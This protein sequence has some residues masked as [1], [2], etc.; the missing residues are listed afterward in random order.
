[1][2]SLGRVMNGQTSEDT[3]R[4]KS[5][6]VAFL[7]AFAC[8]V[9]RYVFLYS[10]FCLLLIHYAIVLCHIPNC[11][12]IHRAAG[13]H[14]Y[15]VLVNLTC[16]LFRIIPMLMNQSF[17]GTKGASGFP[18]PPG[19]T[20]GKGETGLKGEPGPSIPGPPGRTGLNGRDG[21]PGSR[22]EQGLFGPPGPAGDTPG[23]EVGPPGV[24][25]P[26]GEKGFA[27]IGGRNGLP[28]LLGEKGW[29]LYFAVKG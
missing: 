14:F 26:K 19:R 15:I 27:G 29:S 8:F 9:V 12:A 18:G 22:G 16:L 2:F 21:T 28:G 24:D 13:L 10:V 7:V 25:G 17:P 5:D 1:M 3:C 20:G 23:G 6:E 4:I 11:F